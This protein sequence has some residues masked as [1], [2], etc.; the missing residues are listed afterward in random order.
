MTEVCASCKAPVLWVLTENGKRMPV[1]SEPVTHGNLVLS[2]RRVS[3]PPTA[4][5]QGPLEIDR[6]RAEHERSPQTGPL[7]L[8]VS[9]F[10]SCPHAATHRTPTTSRRTT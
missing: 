3:E 10:S 9:H 5:V 1:D 6:L 7:A 4:L 2:H 8:F